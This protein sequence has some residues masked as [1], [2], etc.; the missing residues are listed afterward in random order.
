N[1]GLCG[2]YNG[3]ILRQAVGRLR[4]LRSEGKEVQVE[5]SGKRGLA[6]MKFEKIDISNSYTQFEDKP[7]FEEVNAIADRY[8]K[9]FIAGRLH[10]VD[11]VYQKFLTSARQ[12]PTVE[13]LLPIGDLATGDSTTAAD[14]AIDYEF[15]SSAEE[16][17]E[18]I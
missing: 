2:G 9:D 13:T 15:L 11:V 1:R 10:R 18:E 6:Y 7:S 12:A 17:L 16:I 4:E 3:G 8:V 5:V 14:S